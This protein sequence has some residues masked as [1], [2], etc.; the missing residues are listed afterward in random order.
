MRSDGKP[1]RPGIGKTRRMSRASQ[2]AKQS[3]TRSTETIK[4]SGHMHRINR[5]DTRLYPTNSP[6]SQ[7]FP[8]NVGAIHTR[9]PGRHLLTGSCSHK[10]TLTASQERLP[11]GPS[12]LRR[13][14]PSAATG[15]V[16][17]RFLAVSAANA[18]IESLERVQN[19]PA[20]F[21]Q[22]AEACLRPL[23]SVRVPVG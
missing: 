4:A 15:A 18:F 2:P 19:R 10:Q 5:P 11:S 13:W 12:R 16:I 1:V 22:H 23:T 7:F 6:K 17:F 8:C 20:R 21:G 3:G 9:P 14:E